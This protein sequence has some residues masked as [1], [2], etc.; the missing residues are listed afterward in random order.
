M[1]DPPPSPSPNA[2]SARG[3]TVAVLV[4]TTGSVAVVASLEE[5]PHLGRSTV[6][7]V[8]DF[9]AF[10][11]EK[12]Y[13]RLVDGPLRALGGSAHHTHLTLTARVED[14]RSWELPILIAHRAVQHGARLVAD[15]AT[16]DLVI[17]ATGS[18][19][20]ALNPI[21]HAEFLTQK[22]TNA[23]PLLA[24]MKPGAR[25]LLILGP[26]AAAT[27]LATLEAAAH[28]IPGS[29]T[30]TLSRF[31]ELDHL[32]SERIGAPPAPPSPPVP[33]RVL[34]GLGIAVAVILVAGAIGFGVS[35]LLS[36]DPVPR[37]NPFDMMAIEQLHA[38]DRDA[39][40]DAQMAGY[41]LATQRLVRHAD[42]FHVP[43]SPTTCALRFVNTGTEPIE[44]SLDNGFAGSVIRGDT[45]IGR[46]L[47]LIN[48]TSY[49]L[50]FRRAP[51]GR[52]SVVTVAAPGRVGRLPIT[53]AAGE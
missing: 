5:K 1:S 12:D 10:P 37:G 11:I 49:E 46:P 19:D 3:P 40:I 20:G 23:A 34:W 4:P 21:G 35:T 7:G 27:D 45:P 53:F 43:A 15:V 32:L 42:G 26:P 17:F 25:A 50:V 44:I 33:G 31:D 16:A 41:G 2:D 8:G 38:P 48:G 28:S 51:L 36:K 9:R 52:E 22:I 29:L 14:G 24:T 47:R 30:A 39:C 13:H 18:V 6:T